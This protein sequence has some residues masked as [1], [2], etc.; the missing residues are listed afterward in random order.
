MGEED[1]IAEAEVSLNEGWVEGVGCLYL[2]MLRDMYVRSIYDQ[3]CFTQR[4]GFT[5]G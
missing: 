2:G 1:A 5:G 4:F 3:N